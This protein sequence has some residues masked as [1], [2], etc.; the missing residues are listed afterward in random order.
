MVR[1]S[2][3]WDPFD[4]VVYHDFHLLSHIMGLQDVT[5]PPSKPD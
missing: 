1:L 2:I 4:Q 5:Q 3:D